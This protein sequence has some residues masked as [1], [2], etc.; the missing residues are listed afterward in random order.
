MPE[1]AQVPFAFEYNLPNANWAVF[2]AVLLATVRTG[3]ALRDNQ[4][5]G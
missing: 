4:K 5:K 3:L 2:S 1:I